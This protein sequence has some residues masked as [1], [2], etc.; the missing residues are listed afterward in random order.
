MPVNPKNNSLGLVVGAIAF[1]GLGF[2]SPPAPADDAIN[3][4]N[5]NDQIVCM[6]DN[7][8]W[9]ARNQS[10]RGMMAVAFVVRNRV[11]DKR[12]PHSYCE[13]VKQGPDRSSWKDNT[14]RIPLRHR[15]QF[16][17]FCDGLSDKI[18]M[19]DKAVY[20]MS[21]MIA[22]KV[23]NDELED[24]TN[25]ATHY[26]ADYVRPEWAVTKTKTM[27]IDEHIFYRWEN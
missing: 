8:Y 21:R 2:C 3:A 18:P 16:S 11:N 26:H 12:F 6:A 17:W 7:I 13:V 5:F 10:T 9:E 4:K 15:C 23:Y 24:F 14:V 25:G 19:Y 22:F 27:Q 1:L 20:D